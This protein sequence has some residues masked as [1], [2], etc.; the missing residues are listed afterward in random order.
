[1]LIQRPGF[2]GKLPGKGDFIRRHLSN[3]LVSSLDQ[4]QQAAMEYSQAVLGDAWLRHY[5]VSPIWRF[6][7]SPGLLDTHPIAGIMMPSVDSVGRHFPLTLAQSLSPD[8]NLL[9]FSFQADNW[10]ERMEDVAL[11]AL[12]SEFD[13]LAFE[14]QLEAI[15]TPSLTRP[16]VALPQSEVRRGWKL[17]TLSGAQLVETSLAMEMQSQL[18][19]Q[20]SRFSLWW[21]LGSEDIEPT[22][23]LYQGMPP[24]E[25]FSA[26]I[27]GRWPSN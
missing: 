18:V 5:L 1:M 8:T 14:Q 15:P 11:Y 26:F 10:F 20:Y 7:L 4:W 6:V 13:M 25:A 22:F 3:E 9:G 23:L 17:D 2:Y 16:G 27:S 19:A 21:S 12:S 24:P